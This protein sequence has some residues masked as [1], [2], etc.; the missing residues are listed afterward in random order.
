MP[1]RNKKGGGPSGH[2]QNPGQ[3][4]DRGGP[5]QNFNDRKPNESRPQASSNRPQ[6]DRQSSD[7]YQTGRNQNENR[8]SGPKNFGE[9]NPNSSNRP[10]NS[11]AQSSDNR[12][13]NQTARPNVKNDHRSDRQGKNDRGDHRSPGRHDNR[14]DN[15]HQQYNDSRNSES[16]F[17]N[18]VPK[19]KYTPNPIAPTPKGV[20]AITSVMTPTRQIYKQP[21]Q[22]K[23]S[24]NR[25]KKYDVVFFDTLQSA[26]A[27]IEKIKSL[28]NQCGQLNVIIRAEPSGDDSDIQ[29]F[30][31]VFSGAAWALI[32]ERRTQ[33]GW[34]NAEHE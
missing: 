30:G 11:N 24:S 28:A 23:P 15:R 18:D 32:H 31:K 13:P 21:V 25:L 3:E 29:A 2:S 26:R 7:R 27:E 34:Y 5:T 33:D 19:V 4:H 8:Q 12:G 16:S 17:Q 20:P 14:S 9:R 22:V 10:M 6:N 1:R